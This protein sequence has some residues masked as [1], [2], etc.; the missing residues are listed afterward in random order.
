MTMHRR[1]FLPLLPSLAFAQY[2]ES[3]GDVP[4]VPTPDEVMDTMFGMAEQ[5]AK[6]ASRILGSR[7]Q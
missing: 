1:N 4:W 7:L 6:K 5:K 2:E 3:K